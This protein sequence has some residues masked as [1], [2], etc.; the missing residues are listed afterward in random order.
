MDKPILYIIFNLV[1]TMFLHI[2]KFYFLNEDL[3]VTTIIHF[4]FFFL[5]FLFINF[6]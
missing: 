4:D 3:P 2:S 6:N 5:F 1:D